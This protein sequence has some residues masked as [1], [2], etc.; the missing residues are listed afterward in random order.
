MGP[1]LTE[2]YRRYATTVRFHVDLWPPRQPQAKGKVERRIRAHRGGI[3]PYREAWRDVAEL[4]SS[5]AVR[6]QRADALRRRCPTTGTSVML[7]ASRR[8]R[9]LSTGSVIDYDH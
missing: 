8:V 5:S 1:L 4:Q 3:D 7:D 6:G 9:L 2:A